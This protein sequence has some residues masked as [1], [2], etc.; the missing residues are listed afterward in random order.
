MSLSHTLRLFSLCEMALLTK[1][2]ATIFSGIDYYNNIDTIMIKL[3]VILNIFR[4]NYVNPFHN[5]NKL[6]FKVLRKVASFI[7]F[8]S[9][10]ADLQYKVN[11]MAKMTELT[12]KI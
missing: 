11:L 10:A 7:Y 1:T 12:S 5:S 8:L 3:T 4:S 6:Y 9:P 2:I